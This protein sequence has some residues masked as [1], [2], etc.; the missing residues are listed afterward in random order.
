MYK[1]LPVIM[2]E[3]V[4]G[5]LDF[6]SGSVFGAMLLIPAFAAF[7]A[8]RFCKNRTDKNSVSKPF[9]PSKNIL[10]DT[11]SAIIL[12]VI[13]ICVITPI[14]SFLPVALSANYPIDK[15]FTLDNLSLVF[16]AK[17]GIQFLLNSLFIA[18]SV[19]AIGVCI[20]FLCAYYTSR[21][22]THVSGILHL[23]SI[24]SLGNSRN[25]TRPVICSDIQRE[26]YLRNIRNHNNGKYRA[27]LLV[28]L[29]YDI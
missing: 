11:A 3:E 5:R 24:L 28:A 2:Y 4:I 13:S 12:G 8:D 1:T 7:L 19:S 25:C 23:F 14:I 22:K 29:S 16:S 20:S 6:A 15:T 27:F 21:I 10:R 18:I 9:S 17:N 26:I